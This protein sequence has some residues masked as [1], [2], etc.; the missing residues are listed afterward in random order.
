MKRDW[1]LPLLLLALALLVS[2]VAP[3]RIIVL[4]APKAPPPPIVK[5]P[6]PRKNLFVL[7]PDPDGKTGGIVVENRAGSQWIDQPGQATRVADAATPPAAPQ[8]MEQKE[9]DRIFGPAL[10]AQPVQP[11][12]FILYFKS[13]TSDLTDE[14]LRKLPEIVAAIAGR[15]SADISV[16]GHSDTV[17]AR[18]KNHEISLNRAK[19]VKEILVS[20]GVDARSVDIDSHG[21]DNLL[22]KTPDEVAEAKNRRVEVTIR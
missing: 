11:A 15:K 10:A 8:L 5:P 20:R 2:C 9:I 3:S 17:G 22:V 18:K 19:R 7:M 13:G 21:E 4:P 12:V 14:S 16:V 6:E 1:Y